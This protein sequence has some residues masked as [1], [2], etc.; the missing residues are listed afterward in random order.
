M[1]ININI[2][3]IGF[4]LLP[5]IS[6]G[7][8]SCSSDPTI[9]D[10][11]VLQGDGTAEMGSQWQDGHEKMLNGE[12]LIKK[13][14]EMINDSREEMQKGEDSRTE[15]YK[16]VKSGRQMMDEAEHAYKNRFPHSYQRIYDQQK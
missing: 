7:L 4:L 5:V 12:K 11:M 8:S 14:E 10:R 16:L 15:G 6:T 9:G 3:V 13:G 1:N 2:N